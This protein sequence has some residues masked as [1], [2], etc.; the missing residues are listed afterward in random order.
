[1]SSVVNSVTLKKCCTE[2]VDVG[3]KQ[4]YQIM[5]STIIMMMMI[6]GIASLDCS[7][8]LKSSIAKSPLISRSIYNVDINHCSDSITTCQKSPILS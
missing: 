3:V 2:F 5:T 7:K 6:D 8:L 4:H 1:M